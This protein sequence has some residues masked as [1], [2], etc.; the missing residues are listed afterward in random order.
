MVLDNADENIEFPRGAAVSGSV[1]LGSSEVTAGASV[2]NF[3][4]K[5]VV[6]IAGALLVGFWAYNKYLKK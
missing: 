1:S 4:T 3:P 2:S 5:K 6:F